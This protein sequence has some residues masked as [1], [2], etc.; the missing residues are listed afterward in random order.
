MEYI[1]ELQLLIGFI[2][3]FILSKVNLRNITKAY[4]M[5]MDKFSHKMV[6]GDRKDIFKN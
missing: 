6:Y 5:I 2:F 3:G 4:A 1:N